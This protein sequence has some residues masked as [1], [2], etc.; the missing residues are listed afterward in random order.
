MHWPTD[1]YLELAPKYWL[2]TRAR[3]DAAELDAEVGPLTVPPPIVQLPAPAISAQ[4]P[5]PAVQLP[6]DAR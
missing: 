3:L 6:L 2:A 5:T 1:R 4:L